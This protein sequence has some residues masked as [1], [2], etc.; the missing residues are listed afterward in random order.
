MNAPVSILLVDDH[1]PNLMALEAILDPLGE[2]LVRASSGGQAVALAEHEDFALV[3]LDLQMPQ[4][5]GLETAALLKKLDRCHAVPIIILTADQPSRDTIAQGYA[6]GAV[7]FLSKPLDVDVLRSKVASFVELF[8][9]RAS[10][11]SGT[12]RAATESS[13]RLSDRLIAAA[14]VSGD[15]AE[16]VEALVRIHEAVSE[17][18]DVERIAQRLV[19]EITSLT[20]AQ[21]GAFHWPTRSAMHVALSGSM[22]EELGALGPGSPLMNRVF[23]GVAPL[24][25][26]DHG[27]GMAKVARSVLAVPVFSRGG[28][29]SGAIVLVSDR[30][31]AFDA[32]HQEL[33]VV[34]ARHAASSL[35]NARLYGEAKDARR[36]AE[37]AELELR[38]GE[39]RVRLALE[40][41]GL[42][43]FDSN[44]ITGALRWDA[45]SRVLFGLAPDAPLSFSV[46]R[47]AMHEDDRPRVEV[48]NRAALDPYGDGRYDVEYRTRATFGGAARWIA[49]RGQA[50]V[51]QG[52]AV[53]FL[54]TFLDITARKVVEVER[55]ALLARE[56]EA[57]AEAERAVARAEAASRAKDEFLATVSHELRNPLNA[58]IGWSRVM[59]DEGDQLT[60]ERRRKG[61][62]VVARN[63]KAQ[64]QLVEDILE[65]SRIV[66]GKL[67]LATASVEVRTVIETSIDTLRSA[68]QAKGVALEVSFAN[69]P[70]SIVADEDRLQQVLW[71]LLSNAVK[72]TPRGGSVRIEVARCEDEVVIVV[73][74]T[75]EGIASEFLPFVFERFRQADGSTTRQHGGL[76]LGLAIVRHLVELHGGTVCAHSCGKGR[77]SRFVV[78]LPIHAVSLS[79]ESP[80]PCASSQRPASSP[81]SQDRLDGVHVLV[82]DNEEDMR[83]LIATILEHAGARV[84][85]ASNVSMAVQAIATDCPH[86]AVSDLSMPGEDGYTFVE[87][88]RASS[89]PRTRALPLVAMTGFARDEDR[90]RVLSAGFQR[91]VAKPI[92]P[93][94]LVETLADVAASA[95]GH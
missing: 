58:I 8:R 88:V 46:F 74:D 52:R 57:R 21:G 85:Q 45:R 55:S 44:P 60:P 18:L 40:S 19:D 82:L 90:H 33:A 68:A 59:I 31:W 81:R 29:V 4:L 73:H 24:R 41:A 47:Q 56:Q 7:D 61:L 23:A 50:F 49:A 54:G 94:E 63:A 87:R 92:E 93:A 64:V 71:N 3:L 28:H 1:L 78:T 14:P 12:M 91:H 83:D 5:D 75:G 79:E 17:D 39:A 38:A 67:R 43:T 16:T 15:Q 13:G 77:G 51:E 26:D 37:L 32:R 2:R 22:H 34:A 95:R 69:D 42:G 6:R 9:Q 10:T 80:S 70:A 72:F 11:T 20:E 65:V 30:A 27:G 76:G 89:D 25:L 35:D 66:S 84:T 48:A 36:R 86:L 62:E 53:R